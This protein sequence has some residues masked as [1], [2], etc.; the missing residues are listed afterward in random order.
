M[1]MLARCLS[2]RTLYTSWHI[3]GQDVHVPNTGLPSGGRQRKYSSNSH[4]LYCKIKFNGN[5]ENCDVH[6]GI[7]DILILW[8][9]KAS[10]LDKSTSSLLDN[11]VHSYLWFAILVKIEYEQP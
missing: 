8:I 5:K 4:I 2:W 10:F 6:R 7:S 1:Y 11:Y 3:Y 9:W